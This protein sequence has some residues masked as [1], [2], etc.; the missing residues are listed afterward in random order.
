MRQ[1]ERRLQLWMRLNAGILLAAALPVVFPTDLMAEMHSLLGLGLFPRQPLV[2]YLARSISACYAMHGVVIAMIAADVRTYRPLIPQLYI[3]HLGFAITLVGI[4]L[5]AG[6][7]WWWVI[8]EGGT[9]TGF[10]LVALAL[11]QSCR[12]PSEP[13]KI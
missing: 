5:F 1:C 9:I 2:E 7:P 11:Y 12:T 6:M 3:L 13:A 4:D 8:A 10:A